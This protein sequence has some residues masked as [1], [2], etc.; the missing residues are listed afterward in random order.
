[1]VAAPG[2]DYPIGARQHPDERPLPMAVSQLQ[3]I[4]TRA[5]ERLNSPGVHIYD[6]FIVYNGMRIRDRLKLFIRSLRSPLRK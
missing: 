5:A 4:H 3:A 6:D 2:Q 1:M